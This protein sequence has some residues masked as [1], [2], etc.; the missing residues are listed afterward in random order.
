MT[1]INIFNASPEEIILE[2]NDGPPLHVPPTGDTSS[3]IAQQPEEVVQ[4]SDR[5]STP[6]Q[7][8]YGSNTVRMYRAGQDRNTAQ[9]PKLEVPF[10]GTQV[11][12]LQLYLFWHSAKN[13]AW[14][15]LE[16]GRPLAF[17]DTM[18]ASVLGL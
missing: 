8:R 10:G 11:T 5:A 15:F 16:E 18:V 17:S 12:S 1:A 9:A 4:W 2:I 13:L 14:V 3:W 7:L 6:G